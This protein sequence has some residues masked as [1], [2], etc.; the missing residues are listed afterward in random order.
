[1]ANNSP[2]SQQQQSI[3]KK[4]NNT[5]LPDNLKKG[6]KNLSGMSLDDAKVHRNSDKPAQLQA[7]AYAQG[8]DIH[9]G[10]GQ[11]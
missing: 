2:Q 10:T 3:Q 11:E 1:M 4:E 6:M 9:L 5:G 8:I 7:H